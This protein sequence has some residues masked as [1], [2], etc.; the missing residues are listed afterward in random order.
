MQKSKLLFFMLTIFIS[1]M[2]VAQEPT[3]VGTYTRNLPLNNGG[4]IYYEVNL[5]QDSTFTLIYYRKLA[6]DR[7]EQNT[8]CQGQWKL[9]GPKKVEL[10][11]DSTLFKTPNFINLKETKAH[12]IAKSPRNKSKQNIPTLLKIYQSNI[13]WIKG[14]A[15]EK[16]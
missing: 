16:Q 6:T 10:M 13:P 15:L 7:T 5:H 8:H 1:G 2:V 3:M 11:A 4:K 14:A 9:I 12:F